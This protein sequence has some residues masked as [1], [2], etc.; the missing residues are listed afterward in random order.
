MA[1]W[2]K[3]TAC[4]TAFLLTFLSFANSVSAVAPYSKAFTIS[5]YYSPCPGQA[6][7]AT[8]SYSADI[9]L[10]GNGTNGADGTEVYAGMIAAPRS[11]AFGTKLDIPGIGISA[12][13]DR[14]GAIV[15]AGVRTNVYD[16]LDIWMGYG[17]KGLKRALNWGK[18][19]VTV[20]VYGVD[21][22]IK[23]S[24]GFGDFDANES[25]AN[26]VFGDP[27]APVEYIPTPSYTVAV[28]TNTDEVGRL[29]GNLKKGDSG[30][31]VRLLQN[32]L[33]SLNLF[34]DNATGYYGDVTEHAV[35]KFQ[36]SQTLVWDADS[37]GAGVFG[38]KTRDRMNEIIA[39]RTYSNRMIADATEKHEGVLLA[40]AQEKEKLAVEIVKY[41]F[42]NELQFGMID[43][44]VADLQRFL[45]ERG[46]FKGALVTTYFGKSTQQAVLAFQLDKGVIAAAGDLGAGRV[47][48][49]TLAK[50]HELSA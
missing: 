30:A 35:L 29:T 6:R 21:S 10:N 34:K 9:R 44:Q 17:D 36:Q 38:A 8:G 5:A 3:T 19:D 20:T 18:R 15:D 2:R 23:E 41:S 32:E 31:A 45:K 1:N 7:Y 46:Y 14:G 4:L 11:Y 28:V 42:S 22:S 49:A 47:G 12:I 50:I 43:G 37:E 40:Q 39:G 25:C 27:S 48:P 26:S 33:R 13:H 24:A 16:R